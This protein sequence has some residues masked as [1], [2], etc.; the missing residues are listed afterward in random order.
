[1]PKATFD[2]DLRSEI[3]RYSPSKDQWTKVFVSPMAEG[4]DGFKVPR[5]LALR[6]MIVF[7]GLSDVAPA[8]YVP[9]MGSH[10]TPDAIMLRSGDGL[11][12]EVVNEPCMGFPEAYRPRGVRALTGFK[13]RLFTSPAVGRGRI[14]PNAAG[15]MVVAVNADPA[16]EQ[17][18]LA[19]EPNFGDPGNSTVFDM[20]VFNGYL[21]AG[22]LNV[23]EGFQVWKTDAEGAPPYRWNRVIV[24]GA[25][26][27]KLNQAAITLCSFGGHLYV[28]GAI[29][30]GG[31]DYENKTGPAG[32]EV[33]RINPDDSWDLVVGE[34]R[35]TPE[36]LKVPLSGL[37]PGFG[38]LFAGYIW[39]M[40]EHEG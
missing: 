3:W 18:D 35:V 15:F 8:L 36:G 26:R 13:D 19:C 23:K 17:W 40:C 22:T 12:F 20:A 33:I 16:R 25:Y 10:Q 21:Y 31:W 32:A 4:I 29:Q 39:S 37:G 1:M 24:S 5:I 38:T 6:S 9:G 14:Q 11:N 30:G 28:G 34:P 2:I 7:Q 27:G